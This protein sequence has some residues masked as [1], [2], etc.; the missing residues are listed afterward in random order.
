MGWLELLPLLKRLLPLL[1]RVAPMLETY[2]AARGAVREDVHTAFERFS[3]EVKGDFA[4]ASQNH[5]EVK[6][7][8][9]EHSTR[10]TA[11]NDDVRQ[12]CVTDAHQGALLVEMEKKIAATGRFLRTVSILVLLLL[13]ACFVL[14]TLLFLRH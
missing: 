5:A 6:Q 12:L 10:L 4:I 14:L 1:S 2:V 3:G 7:T 11:L 8:L 9:A 13:V